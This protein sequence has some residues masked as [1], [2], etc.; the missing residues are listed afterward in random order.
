MT[1]T[2]R[3]QEDTYNKLASH[4]WEIATNA[5]PTWVNIWDDGWWIEL[6]TVN[7]G[8]PIWSNLKIILHIG[9]LDYDDPEPIYY[10]DDDNE[11]YKTTWSKRKVVT[12]GELIDTY[13][14]LL[15]FD[16]D[17]QVVAPDTDTLLQQALMGE[18][19]YA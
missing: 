5:M 13:V 9:E 19:K 14:S 16:Y 11:C 4:V 18:I 1:K 17:N 8:D 10:D 12:M 6:T 2:K 15:Q 3:I 7:Y